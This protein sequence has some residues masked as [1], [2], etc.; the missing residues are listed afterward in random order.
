MATPTG[1]H[2]QISTSLNFA[3]NVVDDDG[4]YRTNYSPPFNI[5]ARGVPLYVRARHKDNN[6]AYSDWGASKQ[7]SIRTYEKWASYGNGFSFL[8]EEIHG[9]TVSTDGSVLVCG[10]RNGDDDGGGPDYND[11][12][13]L[14]KWDE[15]GN[16]L[17]SATT[18]NTGTGTR[19]ILNVCTDP[20][21]NI[22]GI[23]SD[24]ILLK[25]DKNGNF[26][27]KKQ[28]NLGTLNLCIDS[29][30]TY[31]YL[32][33]YAYN[34][35]GIIKVN[36]TTGAVI[37]QKNLSNYNSYL[38]DISIK[39]DTIYSVGIIS[40]NNINYGYVV[41][42]STSGTINNQKYI[43]NTTEHTYFTKCSIDAN[44]NLYISGYTSGGT[45][46]I[47][48]KLFPSLEK[49]WFFKLTSPSV[50]HSILYD[51]SGL[52]IVGHI[53]TGSWARGIIV[54]FNTTTNSIEWSVLLSCSAQTRF[55][56]ITNGITTNSNIYAIATIGSDTTGSGNYYRPVL[57]TITP[58]KPIVGTLPSLSSISWATDNSVFQDITNLMINT[59]VPA[60]YT[61][62]TVITMTDVNLT[63]LFDAAS[64]LS[65]IKSVY[66]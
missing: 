11:Y 28:T 22:Y 66:S 24:F 21:D 59:A 23:T 37:W 40:M 55:K 50:F 46:A 58:D 26:I 43:G 5:L 12:M 16:L 20:L 47:A 33:G 25:W 9:C 3:T 13:H 4:A 8:I 14:F 65:T 57:L 29:T 17:W 39:N 7:F 64:Q 61:D 35:A 1:T 56:G 2:I 48:G 18:L 36:A 41:K 49:D 10:Y 51:T 62:L 15:D 60:V 44:L 34:R 52:Y 53:T 42:L 54:K 6:N 30:G 45:Y 38:Y 32:C 27:Y 19:P 63:W 31:L